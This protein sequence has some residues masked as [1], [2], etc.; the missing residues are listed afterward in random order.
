MD[1]YLI[2]SYLGEDHVHGI[3]SVLGLKLGEIDDISAI[4]CELITQEE[5]NEKHLSDDINKV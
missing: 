2:V 4:C 1:L 3:T 5:V